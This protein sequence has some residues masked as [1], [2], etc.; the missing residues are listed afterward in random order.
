ELNVAIRTFEFAAGRSWLGAGGGIVADSDPEAEYAECLI[1]ATPLITAIGARLD[2]NR[3]TEPDDP[4]GPDALNRLAPRPSAGVFSSLLVTDGQ[5]RGLAD[6]LARLASSVRDLYGKEL[7]A[8]LQADLA[9]C[10]ASA[11]TGRLRISVRPV[12]GPLQAT[13]EVAPLRPATA[14]AAAVGAITLRPTTVAGGIG[15]RKWRDRRLLGE[16]GA[17]AGPA[18]RGE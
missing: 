13:V 1:K 7:P 12:G 15:G 17:R 11:P 14:P 5:T 4:G 18:G 16:L 2:V 10:L 3:A 8:R 6:H 9:A